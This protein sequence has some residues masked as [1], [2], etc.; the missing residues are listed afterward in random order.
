MNWGT[1]GT[2]L[3]FV[4]S[5]NRPLMVPY[6]EAGLNSPPSYNLLGFPVVIDQGC[7]AFSLTATANPVPV[8][9]AYLAFGD[10][11]QAFVIRDVQGIG[12]A[13]DPYTGIGTND[14][15]YYGYARTD[16]T[17]KNFSAYELLG[18][19]HV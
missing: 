4:D 2:L 14:V 18:G 19:Y 11:S 9:K 13:V 3:G 7:P 5:T 1:H 12:I 16:S 8:N 6:A 10:L 17:V 15:L